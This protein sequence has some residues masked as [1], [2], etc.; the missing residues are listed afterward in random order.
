MNGLNI[1]PGTKYAITASSEVL[2]QELIHLKREKIRVTS[3]SPGITRTEIMKA[4]GGESEESFAD[5][6]P[7]LNPEDVAHGVLYILSTPSH[8]QVYEL[9]LKPVGETMC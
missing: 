5:T 4:A 8:V 3:L 7:S 1:Y 6:M 9:T 2:R